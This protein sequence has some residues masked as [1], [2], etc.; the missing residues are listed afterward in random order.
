MDKQKLNRITWMFVATTVLVVALMLGNTLRRTDRIT[1]PEPGD[2]PG[3]SV[4]GPAGGSA[5]TVVEVTPE[6]VQA[7]VGT[8][9]R[10]ESYRRTV[11]V[12]QLWSGGSGTFSTT[13]S[14]SGG[15][16][17]TDRALPDGRTRHTVTNGEVTHIWYDQE[18]TV[19]TAPAG[20]VSADQEQAI[21][22]YEDILSLPV[23]SIAAADYRTFSDVNCIYVE[24]A[25]GP[26]G[27]ALRYWVSVDTGLLAAAE[28]LLNGETVYRMAALSLDAALPVTADFTLPD[29]T[30]LTEM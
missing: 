9:A 12:E 29:G 4:E 22:T 1:L 15:W 5:L 7:A 8:L 18:E 10:P 17:R 30:V 26:E 19:Y 11:T 2:T 28:K 14:V 13:A 16:T 23:S 27:Y 20:E 21:P 24:T 3:Q 6:T 25:E